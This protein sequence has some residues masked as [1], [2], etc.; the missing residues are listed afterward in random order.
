MKLFKAHQDMPG[1]DDYPPRREPYVMTALYARIVCYA[2]GDSVAADANACGR[3]GHGLKRP[4]AR[5]EHTLAA[6]S[7]F[8]THCGHVTA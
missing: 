7:R 6:G 1:Q 2:C 3:C 5:C 8:C 4:C